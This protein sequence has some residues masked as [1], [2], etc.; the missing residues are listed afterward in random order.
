MKELQFDLL[1][2]ENVPKIEFEQEVEIDCK[3][4]GF[5][6]RSRLH[7]VY[8]QAQ[9]STIDKA[10][11]EFIEKRRFSQAQYQAAHLRKCL[12]NHL[13]L[14]EK[15]ELYALLDN[16]RFL[17][18]DTLGLL[19]TKP[20]HVESNPMPSFFMDVHSLFQKPTKEQQSQT[21]LPP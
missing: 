5:W 12:P 18:K 16:H 13:S 17:F 15:E 19:P 10:E 7:Q 9:Q 1:Y 20:V 8:F 2:S 4:R 3:P 11:E 6:S 21:P 14:Q